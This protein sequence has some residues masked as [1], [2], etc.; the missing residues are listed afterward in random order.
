MSNLYLPVPATAQLWSNRT[1]LVFTVLVQWKDHTCA[2]LLPVC[3]CPQRGRQRESAAATPP[4]TFHRLYHSVTFYRAHLLIGLQPPQS[5]RSSWLLWIDQ[6]T[7][8]VMMKLCCL[9]KDFEINW[10]KTHVETRHLWFVTILHYY[11]IIFTHLRL[12]PWMIDQKM[13]EKINE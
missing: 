13:M 8:T 6:K 3:W 9:L 5:C 12:S 2:F 10:F 4:V 1:P 7:S 11:I